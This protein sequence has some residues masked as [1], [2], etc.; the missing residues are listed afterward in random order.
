[1]G[2][3]MLPGSSPSSPPSL[4]LSSEA[5]LFLRSSWALL[6]LLS[7]FSAQTLSPLVPGEDSDHMERPQPVCQAARIADPRVEAGFVGPQDTCGLV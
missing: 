2:P 5:C 4:R 7:G 3:K 6:V 1:M